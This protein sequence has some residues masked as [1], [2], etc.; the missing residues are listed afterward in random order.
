M[1]RFTLIGVPSS[2]GTHGVGQEKAPMQLRRAGLVERLLGIGLDLVDDGD[3]P[4]MLYRSRSPDRRQQN[5]DRVVTVA[6]RVADRVAQTV[7]AGRVPLVLG[8]DCTITLGVVAGLLRHHPDVGLLYFDGD[9]D[10]S[11]PA[12]SQS[13]ILDA[14]GVAHLLGDGAPALARV[15]PRHPMLPAERLLLFGFDPVE[16]GRDMLAEVSRRGLPAWPVTSI[17]GRSDQAAAEALA[18]LEQVADPVLVH[19]DVDAID[20]TDFPLANFPHFN[21]G[22]PFDSAMTCLARFCGGSK[23]GGLVV[24]EVNPD[25]DADGSLLAELVDGITAALERTL[26]A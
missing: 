3:L 6:A 13:G 25:H 12:E 21:L 17:I 26:Q 15:G 7:A 5:L 11:T 20:S 23:F 18:A 19:F 24:T 1:T 8:G 2:A 16:V 9:V 22:Q 14:M 10:L 4:L